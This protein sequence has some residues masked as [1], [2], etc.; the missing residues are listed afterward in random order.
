MLYLQACFEVYLE[1]AKDAGLTLTEYKT[2]TYAK[3]ISDTL[4]NYSPQE[5]LEAANLFCWPLELGLV[6]MK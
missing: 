2:E 5:I 4:N 1:K 6:V 3:E